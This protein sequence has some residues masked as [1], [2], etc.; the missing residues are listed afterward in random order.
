MN[1]SPIE[2]VEG[3]RTVIS[4]MAMAALDNTL[5]KGQRSGDATKTTAS[6][7]IDVVDT[8]MPTIDANVETHVVSL[9][10]YR[11][12]TSGRRTDIR[13]NKKDREMQLARIREQKEYSQE[14]SVEDR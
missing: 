14:L 5:E 8:L 11:E 10:G 2:N 13:I 12:L 6:A 4:F 3:A 1:R 7:T 9:D